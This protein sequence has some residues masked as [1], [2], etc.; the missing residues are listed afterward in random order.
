[1]RARADA[2]RKCSCSGRARTNVG[3]RVHTQTKFA[4]RRDVEA[5]VLIECA[6]AL[7]FQRSSVNIE[8][9]VKMQQSWP[10]VRMHSD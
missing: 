2:I 1:M 10:D 3:H 9:T 6:Q 7:P 8:L 5:G 4:S